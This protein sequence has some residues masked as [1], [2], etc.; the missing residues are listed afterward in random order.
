[1]GGGRGQDGT[2]RPLA[3]SVMAGAMMAGSEVCVPAVPLAFQGSPEELRACGLRSQ[4]LVGAQAASPGSKATTGLQAALS[5]QHHLTQWCPPTM[6]LL[7]L[8][9]HCS[10]AV[11]RLVV[12]PLQLASRWHLKV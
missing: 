6:E 11:W 2:L 10:E 1:M 8:S 5:P 7:Y 4:I 9:R 12:P 3:A